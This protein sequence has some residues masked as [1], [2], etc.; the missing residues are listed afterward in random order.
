MDTRKK[1]EKINWTQIKSGNTCYIIKT[2]SLIR[3]FCISLRPFF[4]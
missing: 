2:K 1:I 3:I 4:S